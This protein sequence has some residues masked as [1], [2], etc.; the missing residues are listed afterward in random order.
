MEEYTYE[1]Q[2]RKGTLHTNADGMSRLPCDK[3]VCICSGVAELEMLQGLQDS[4]VEQALLN[5][6]KF[7][8]VYTAEEMAAAQLADPDIKPLYV[9]KIVNQIRPP[10]NEISGESPAAK[11][12][13][14]EWKRVEAHDNMLYRR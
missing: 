5:M 1:I 11:A 9:A 8:P 14:A 3:K 13:M 10:W 12:Y 2:V 4:G 6:I 7:L